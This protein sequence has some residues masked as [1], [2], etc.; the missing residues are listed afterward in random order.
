MGS[1][2][3]SDARRVAPSPKSIDGNVSDWTGVPTRLAGTSIYS[4]GEYVYQ[5]HID[6]AWG[7]DD[8]TD[9]QRV[10]QN[11]PLMNAEPR[12]YRP[13]EAFPQAAGDQ[14]GAP[15]PPGALL[16]YG[17]TA[18]ND[19][20]R[21]AADIVEARLA[22]SSS[23]LDFLVRTTGMTAAAKPAVLVLLDTRAGG[24]YHLARAMG[25]LTTGAEWA[26]LF[27]DATHA[28]VSHLGGAPA[29]LDATAV[30]N[31]EAYTNAVEISVARAT[32]TD[33]TDAVGVGIATGVPD[34]A[35]HLLAAKAP[36]GAASDLINVAFRNE[37]ARIWMDENQ[38]FALRDRNIDKF[39]AR[40]QIRKLLDGST[41]TFQQRP[42]YYERI[43]EDAGTPVNTDTMDDS[44]FQGAWQH[45]GV[46]IPVGWS[47][48]SYVPAT[49][50][51]HYRGGHAN[52]AASWEPGILRQFGDETGAIVFTPSARGSSSWYTG[53]GMVDFMD[54]WHDALS[55][56]RVDRDRIDL[57]GHSMGGWA[58]YLLGLLFPDR[59]AA[60]N[61]EDG[62]LAPGLWTGFS[63][64][65]DPQDG[66]DVNAEFLA[67]LIGNARNL[68]YAILHG[69]EDELVPVTSAIKSA[70]VFQQA[71]YRYRLYLF[72]TYE[73][74]SAPIWDDWRDVVRYMRSFARDPNPSHVTYTISPA[75]DHAVSTVSAPKGVDLGYVF[76]SAYWT[77]GLQTRAS[78]LSPSNLGT[79]DAVTYGRGVQDVLDIPE[80]GALAQP[81]VYTMVGQRWLA[82]GFAPPANKFTATLTNLRAA[83]LD[84]ARMG[85][86]RRRC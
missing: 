44:Y 71:G 84:V 53:R 1:L 73:H 62:L 79:I 64:P 19:V 38:A 65:S 41:Q 14:F 18:A 48:R 26:L 49:F 61:P 78:G 52:D 57:A 59:W 27:A 47:P 16:N 32:V 7:A 13:F 68:P 24:T 22:A 50:W 77:S 20:Q 5:D 66:G 42:G 58:S 39:L 74:Y 67:P 70:T 33:L 3:V 81:E 6:D 46:Y 35:T 76:N 8:G 75:L 43:Y 36:A 55:H 63:A 30:W 11:A 28:W 60:S 10:A 15:R 17:D 56:Y 9:E 2:V 40:I 25:G 86:R 29:P 12:L 45:Y 80:A 31:P 54:V 85:S 51:M 69:T 34:P 37:P 23:A 83:T 72:H 4:R 21:N 82:N